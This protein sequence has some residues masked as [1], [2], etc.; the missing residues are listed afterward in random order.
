M[1]FV[2][3][4]LGMGEGSGKNIQKLSLMRCHQLGMVRTY[5]LCQKSAL[6]WCKAETLG[7][8]IAAEGFCIFFQPCHK[9]GWW[10]HRVH[11]DVWMGLFLLRPQHWQQPWEVSAVLMPV[12][13][14]A[15]GVL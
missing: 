6:H 10:N 7:G 9:E 12:S 4:D 3:K 13:C 1:F 5:F 8:K 2:G 11:G 14:K 15:D